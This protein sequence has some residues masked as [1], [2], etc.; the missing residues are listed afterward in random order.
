MLRSRT[1]LCVAMA[2]MFGCSTVEPAAIGEGALT[3]SVGVL[4][5]ERSAAAD[6]PLDEGAVLRAAFARYDGIDGDSVLRLLGS[7]TAAE[8]DRCTMLE[9]GALALD[10]ASA[11]AADHPMVEPG[12]EL[13]D[14]GAL[15][16]EVASAS[17]E[18]GPDE[19][20]EAELVARTFPDLAS[21]LAGVFYA[22]ELNAEFFADNSLPAVVPAVEYRFVAAGSTDV[23]AF[24]V[25]LSAVDAPRSIA[26]VGED[27]TGGA[28]DS[29]VT[30]VGTD[31]DLTLAWSAGD[32]AD[33]VEIEL[34]SAG[35]TLAC[36]TRD[37]GSF[38]IPASDLGALTS[39]PDAR[40]VVRRVRLE[41]FEAIGMDAAYARSAAARTFPLSVR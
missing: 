25:V 20:V 2:L 13:V 28:L 26:L 34:V 41:P 36:A 9:P 19:M 12:V 23:G 37:E 6:Q 40:L 8:L 24:D 33:L 18:G 32:P 29:R 1:G 35:R 27:G 30:D 7:G 21:V 31:G 39:D 5:V 10:V 16:V 4:H 14:V 11:D 17:N 38:S 3:G 22:E 15:R